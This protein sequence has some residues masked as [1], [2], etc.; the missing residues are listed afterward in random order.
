MAVD[1]GESGTVECLPTV[2][3]FRLSFV[4]DDPDQFSYLDSLTQAIDTTNI[5]LAF[6]A[7]KGQYYRTRSRTL[8]YERGVGGWRYVISC[9]VSLC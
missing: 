9:V 2:C 6:A 3:R 5:R 1:A 8:G 4:R 7:V